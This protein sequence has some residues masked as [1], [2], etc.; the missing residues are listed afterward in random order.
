M[1]LCSCPGLGCSQVVMQVANLLTESGVTDLPTIQA[2]LLHDTV[3]RLSSL[4]S[5]QNLKPLRWYQVEDTETTPEE[6]DRHFGAEVRKIVMECTDDKTLPKARRKELQ[7]LTAGKKSDAASG[8][9]WLP[10]LVCRKP[11]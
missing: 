11:S 1:A 9:S 6:L 7:V 3:G 2:A 10:C 4:A 8:F 5:S